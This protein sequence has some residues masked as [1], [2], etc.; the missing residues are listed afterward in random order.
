LLEISCGRVEAGVCYNPRMQ[1]A[2]NGVSWTATA[3]DE[4]K[5]I[6]HSELGAW[7]GPN[8]E[9][10]KAEVIFTPG[11]YFESDGKITVKVTLLADSDPGR[12]RSRQEYVPKK[13]GPKNAALTAIAALEKLRQKWPKPPPML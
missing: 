10:Q 5:G 12:G 7:V 1:T 8:G 6:P 11:Y 13:D 3:Y 4:L 9:F 2:N